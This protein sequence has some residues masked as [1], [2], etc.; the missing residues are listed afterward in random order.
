MSAVDRQA[1]WQNVYTSKAEKDVRWLQ[2]RPAISLDLISASG[3]ETG[4]AIVDI[5][6]GA[7]RLV[8]ALLDA[9]YHNLTVLDLSDA[10]LAV[11]R[12]QSG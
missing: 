12:E 5:G 10:A 2:D 9:G 4:S 6:G 11:A 3:A 8:D 7:P 1:R